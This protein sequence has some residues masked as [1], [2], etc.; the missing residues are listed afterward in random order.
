[1]K[2]PIALLVCGA[3]LLASAGSTFALQD[4][5]DEARE[6]LR[7]VVKI[8][9]EVPD[10]ARSAK[11]L[12]TERD[13]SGVVI[14]A[15]G[16]I[17]T[18]GYLINEA[19]TL[20]VTDAD[21]KSVKAET[22]AYD[23]RTGFGIIK[24]ARPLQLKPI[25]MGRSSEVKEGDSVLVA[26]FGG[27]EA[28]IGARVISR[29]EFAGYWEYLLENAIFTAP[30]HPNFGGAALISRSGKL[31][32]IGSLFTQMAIS[33]LGTLP[34]NVFIPIDDLKPILSDLI[35]KG[36]TGDLP[37]P[38]LG[39]NAEET[40]GRVILTRITPESPAEKAGLKT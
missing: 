27:E 31:M 17:L 36:R 15:K 23:F 10:Y 33:G 26:A 4:A 32:G 3:L 16:H 39:V 11:T 20:E 38:W 14:D 18:I 30:A 5:K 2:N 8:H 21:G 25:E 7:S 28:A 19:E 9:A 24:T 1:M 37:R 22:V 12:G 6:I 34:G 35:A 29:K 13:G 40:H